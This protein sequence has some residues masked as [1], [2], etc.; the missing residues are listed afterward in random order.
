MS[1]GPL[2]GGNGMCV[3][4]S[5]KAERCV[6]CVSGASST[7]GRL[8]LHKPYLALYRLSHLGRGRFSSYA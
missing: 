8:G 6:E 5:H 4:L 2:G 7:R 3:V 1:T